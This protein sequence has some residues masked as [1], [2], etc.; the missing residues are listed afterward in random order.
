M[1]RQRFCIESIAASSRPQLQS[2]AI[3]SNTHTNGDA[4]A[5]TRRIRNA[6]RRNACRTLAARLQG[7]Q[8]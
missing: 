8:R 7:A 6:Q 5:R 3:F 2:L 1:S 4:A